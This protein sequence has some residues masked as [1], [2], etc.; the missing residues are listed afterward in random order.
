MNRRV[1]RVSEKTC[2]SLQRSAYGKHW[3]KAP[4]NRRR[5]GQLAL[6]GG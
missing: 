5:Q 6:R 1:P 4:S 2:S 3:V